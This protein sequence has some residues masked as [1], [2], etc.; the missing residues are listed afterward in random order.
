M[1]IYIYICILDSGH[2]QPTSSWHTCVLDS[3]LNMLVVVAL[4]RYQLTLG[5]LTTGWSLCRIPNWIWVSEYWISYAHPIFA[6]RLCTECVFGVGY[7]WFKF[8]FCAGSQ[9]WIWVLCRILFV[10]IPVCAGS[11]FWIWGLCRILFVEICFVPDLG[12]EVWF[13][14]GSSVLIMS[15]VPDL[16]FW[17]WVLCRIM[18]V[19]ILF[20]AGSR[21]WIWVLCRIGCQSFVT[22]PVCW[23]LV[24]CRIP[25]LILGFVTDHIFQQWFCDGWEPDSSQ[26]YLATPKLL[27]YC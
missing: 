6:L 21:F 9:F 17:I 25:F 26:N 4:K 3:S 23:N 18:F 15:F 27:W 13:C 8:P 14:D 19:E 24:L 20:C 22:D 10:E 5:F 1:Y 16:V 12:F 2:S 11:Q 7:C